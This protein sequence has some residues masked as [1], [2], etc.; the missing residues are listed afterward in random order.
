MGPGTAGTKAFSNNHKSIGSSGGKEGGH[1]GLYRSDDCGAVDESPMEY[2][3][4]VG[5]PV[6]G[7]GVAPQ[8][9]FDCIRSEWWNWKF[10]KVDGPGSSSGGSS[11]LHPDR[12]GTVKGL[13]QR[14]NTLQTALHM[15]LKA[16]PS[17]SRHQNR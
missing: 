10:P 6:P 11:K 7:Q 15:P 4:R 1:S 5:C 2:N 3:Q 8:N 9:I 14:S 16:L 12:T 13:Q 17:R